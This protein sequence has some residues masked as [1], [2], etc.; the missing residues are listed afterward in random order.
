MNQNMNLKKVIKRLRN[1]KKF[2]QGLNICFK[3]RKMKIRFK[4]GDIKRKIIKSI[5]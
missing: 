2:V 3:K 4:I 1:S 5:Q